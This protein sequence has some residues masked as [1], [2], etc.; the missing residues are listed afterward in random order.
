MLEIARLTKSFGGEEARGAPAT[1]VLDGVSFSVPEN[2]FVCLLGPSGC[3]KTT[4]LRIVAGLT[5]ADSGSVA[6]DGTPVS[7]PGSDRALVFQ[8]YGLLPWR[9]VL[10]NVEFGLEVQGAARARRRQIARDVIGRVGLTGFEHYYPHQISGGMQQRVAL[11]RALAKDP[12]VLLMDEPFAAVDMLTREMLQLELLRI[13]AT[14]KT[15]VLFV[16][17]SIE[18]AILLSDR[19]IVMGAR[20]GRIDADVLTGLP[21]PRTDDVVQSPR[22]DELRHILRQALHG[23]VVPAVA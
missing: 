10:G 19:V 21:R 15:T 6:V 9:T 12:K 7:R 14:T 13:W 16:T 5:E 20:P 1:H 18:E 17:H 2:Q 22:F 23:S 3:G 4:L 8:N 11:A